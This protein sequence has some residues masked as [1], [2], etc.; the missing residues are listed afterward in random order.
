MVPLQVNMKI[1]G[2]L[3]KMKLDEIYISIR[4][5]ASIHGPKCAFPNEIFLREAICTLLKR[6]NCKELCRFDS[7]GSI[8]TWGG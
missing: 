8:S 1:Q 5:L 4:K 2:S 7:F 6:C 3:H